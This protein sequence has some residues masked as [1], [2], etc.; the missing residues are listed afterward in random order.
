MSVNNGSPLHELSLAVPVVHWSALR[1]VGHSLQ[2]ILS[3]T[4]FLLSFLGAFGSDL[5]K[6]LGQPP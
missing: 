2:L 1:L 5:I 3:F 6:E 4:P